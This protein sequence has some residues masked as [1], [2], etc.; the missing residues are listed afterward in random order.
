MHEYHIN[1]NTNIDY[2]M[3]LNIFRT[4]RQGFKGS[5]QNTMMQFNEQVTKLCSLIQI[6]SSSIVTSTSLSL[7]TDSF[8]Q[9]F[10]VFHGNN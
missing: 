8:S 4:E 1:T 6:V 3:E 2:R 5:V 7:S 9:T 10:S